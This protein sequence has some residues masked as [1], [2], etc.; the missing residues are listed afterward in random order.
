MESIEELGDFLKRKVY[1]M[2]SYYEKRKSLAQS[3]N[4]K[5]SR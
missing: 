3:I 1:M 5:I 2:K 4:L